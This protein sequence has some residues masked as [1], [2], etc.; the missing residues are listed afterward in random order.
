MSLKKNY[1]IDIFVIF[2]IFIFDRI[3][4]LYV[5]NLSENFERLDLEIT[6]FLNLKLI[7]NDGIAF[8]LLSS[9]QEIVYNIISFLIFL[10][11]TYILFKSFKTTGFEKFFYILISGGALGNFYDRLVYKSVPDFIDLHY[12]Q[13]NWFIFNLADIF[14]SIGIIFLIMYEIFLSKKSNE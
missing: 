1:Y 14:I 5:I 2:L 13:F 11:I 4:K 12:E 9:N 7:W 6:S 8:G 10:I 3:S